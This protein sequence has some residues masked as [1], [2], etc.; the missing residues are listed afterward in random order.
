M[1]RSG[2]TK[3]PKKEHTGNEDDIAEEEVTYQYNTKHFNIGTMMI[4]TNS[5]SSQELET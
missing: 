4:N 5:N 3:M 1:P 2:K